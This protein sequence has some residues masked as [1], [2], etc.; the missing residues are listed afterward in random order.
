MRYG[1][2]GNATRWAGLLGERARGLTYSQAADFRPDPFL[3]VFLT[4]R[5]L[6][7]RPVETPALPGDRTLNQPPRHWPG[8]RS[9][10]RS[11]HS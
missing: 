1:S 10:V 5:G 3:G 2:P 9:M 8:D 4:S 6:L 7:I 11:G